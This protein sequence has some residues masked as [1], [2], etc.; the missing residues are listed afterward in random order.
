MKSKQVAALLALFLGF[1]GA[2]HFYLGNK[3][4]GVIYLGISLL[5]AVF[6]MYGIGIIGIVVMAVVLLFDVVNLF[7]ISERKFNRKYNN[8]LKSDNDG[9]KLAA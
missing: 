9:R 4:L 2:H 6:V 1:L 8:T 5:S 7:A 3:N